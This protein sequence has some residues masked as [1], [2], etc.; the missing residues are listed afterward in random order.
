MGSVEDQ[1][2]FIIY[3]M[4]NLVGILFLLAGIKYPKTARLMFVLLFVWAGWVNYTTAHN[5]PAAYLNYAETSAGIYRSFITGWFSRHITIVVSMIAI[6]QWLI[7][8]GMLLND[9]WV[10]LA[11]IGAIVFLLAIT[12]LGVGSA[13]PFS[14]SVSLAAFFVVRSNARDYL[15]KYRKHA[16]REFIHADVNQ[17]KR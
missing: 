6:G 14:I 2:Y 12:P 7:A 8:L 13:F 10:K 17:H 4:F 5:N 16:R 15:W 1:S 9:R 3:L 11:C